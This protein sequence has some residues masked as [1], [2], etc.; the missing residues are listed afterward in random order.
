MYYSI[1]FFP[2]CTVLF[3]FFVQISF[4]G[5]PG[6][7]FPEQFRKPVGPAGQVQ[8]PEKG[9]QAGGGVVLIGTTLIPL[10]SGLF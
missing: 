4:R 6:P 10:L 2:P 7:D 1:R 9:L 3:L 8:V 5:R